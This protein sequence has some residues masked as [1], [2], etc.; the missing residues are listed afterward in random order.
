MFRRI[1]LLCIGLMFCSLLSELIAQDRE[2]EFRRYS[3]PES[4]SGTVL[5]IFQDSQGFLWFASEA[6]LYRFNGHDIKQ[7]SY[8]PSDSIS[9]STGLIRDFF[10]DSHGNLW[11]TTSQSGLNRIDL[12][13]DEI[14]HFPYDPTDS[15]T[16]DFKRTLPGTG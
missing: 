2:F 3:F 12:V 14:T 16:L 6:G 5:D 15:T 7:Y 1:A 4:M 8:N 10:E 13:T 11:V 9:L